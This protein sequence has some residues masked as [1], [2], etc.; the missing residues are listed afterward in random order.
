MNVKELVNSKL[1][2]YGMTALITVA[3]KGLSEKDN[4]GMTALMYACQNGHYETAKLLIKYGADVN[5]QDKFGNTA[6]MIAKRNLITVDRKLKNIIGLLEIYRQKGGK[7][8][9]D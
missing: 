4:F 1:N 7:N 2:C 5:I 6:L 3:K 8:E 9:R